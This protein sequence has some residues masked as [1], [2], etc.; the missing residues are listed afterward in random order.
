MRGNPREDAHRHILFPAAQLIMQQDTWTPVALLTDGFA[1]LTSRARPALDQRRADR[2]VRAYR[3]GARR[4]VP[5]DNGYRPPRPAR[6]A[7][8]HRHGSG[9]GAD[10][11]GSADASRRADGPAV[12]RPGFRALRHAVGRERQR[13]VALAVAARTRPADR[14]DPP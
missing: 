7:A 4:H 11:V 5:A 12:L 8:R 6:G 3:R 2:A 13:A 10:G 9:R 1:S 14:A